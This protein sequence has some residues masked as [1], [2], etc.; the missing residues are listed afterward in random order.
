MKFVEQR[1][2]ECYKFLNVEVYTH[3]S[4]IFTKVLRI[5]NGLYLLPLCH[6]ISLCLVL[7]GPRA[8]KWPIGRNEREASLEIL[9]SS[10]T[11]LPILRTELPILGR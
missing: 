8:T 7:K 10:R 5:Y 1:Q 3:G 11:K 9:C 4:L 2:A 6:F